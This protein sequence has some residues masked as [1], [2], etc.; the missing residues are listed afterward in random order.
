MVQ[1]VYGAVSS[2]V[3]C[4]G[5]V[6]KVLAELLD[7]ICD[8]QAGLDATSSSDARA[9]QQQQPQYELA[10]APQQHAAM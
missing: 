3:V 2:F 1:I 4:M 6:S 7:L 10:R 5:W 9:P 8:I